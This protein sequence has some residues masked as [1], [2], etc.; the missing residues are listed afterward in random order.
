MDRS[1][2]LLGFAAELELV[3]VDY[4]LCGGIAVAFHGDAHFTKDPG[5]P[6]DIDLLAQARDLERVRIV[7]CNRGLILDGLPVLL[8]AGTSNERELLRFTKAD[9]S[10]SLTVA[11]LHGGDKLAR[12]WQTRSRIVWRGRELHVV[13]LEGLARMRMLTDRAQGP[14]DIGALARHPNKGEPRA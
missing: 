1:E 5:Y 6:K 2:E 14:S 10:D 13:S 11:L 3:G 4:A 9:G 7:A 8:G 12:A